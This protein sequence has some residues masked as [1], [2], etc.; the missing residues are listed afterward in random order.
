MAEEEKEKA[1]AGMNP[2]HNVN[3]G[4]FLLLSIDRYSEHPVY[5]VFI[6]LLFKTDLYLVS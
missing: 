1:V 2:L 4:A 6:I 5:I 3:M